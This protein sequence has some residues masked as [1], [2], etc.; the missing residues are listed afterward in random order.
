MPGLA[1]ASVGRAARGEALAPGSPSAVAVEGSAGSAVIA[2]VEDEPG[3]RSLVERI[4]V[5][6]GHR[7]LA[8]PDGASAIDALIGSGT[9]ID[10]LLTDLV[11][12]GANGFEV[13]RRF[14]R[15]RP[16]LPVMLMSGY[17]ADALDAEGIA[18]GSIEILAKPFSA[19]EL[20]E[21]VAA[22]LTPGSGGT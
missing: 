16:E 3:V 6:G 17:A 1:G 7:V 21:R 14:R 11:M 2:V 15:D 13:A 20:L 12:P 18:E 5:R 19:A 10:L 8:F 22:V 4:L 9:A